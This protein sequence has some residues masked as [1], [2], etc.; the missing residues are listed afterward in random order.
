MAYFQHVWDISKRL[1]HIVSL[2]AGLS[3]EYFDAAF[4][5]PTAVLRYIHYLPEVSRPLESVYAS[6]PHTDYGFF[7]LLLVKDGASG[8]QIYRG[9]DLT[10]EQ[11]KSIEPS[12]LEMQEPHYFDVAP[13]PDP[14]TM[15]I[16]NI[17][18][19]LAVASG[20]AYK[21]TRHRVVLREGASDRYSIP[22]FFEPSLDTPFQHFNVSGSS[23]LAV[24]EVDLEQDYAAHLMKKSAP[25]SS[26]EP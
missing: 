21:A 9:P 11:K 4:E 25:S 1:L 18:D 7:T 16:C 15:F 17:G 23:D 5:R 6:S 2:S 12:I 14:S 24:E 22:F 13:P 8:L 3:A 26:E 10:K 19:A 20:G